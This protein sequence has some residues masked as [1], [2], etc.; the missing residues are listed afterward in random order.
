MK[1]N[2]VTIAMALVL[3]AEA[4]PATEAADLLTFVIAIWRCQRLSVLLS[5]FWD[6]TGGKR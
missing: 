4:V 3:L 6:D 2:V 5:R 1:N